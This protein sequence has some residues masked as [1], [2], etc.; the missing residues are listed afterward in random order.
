[1]ICVYEWAQTILAT[2]NCYGPL[3]ERLAPVFNTGAC[4][5]TLLM[6]TLTATTV[7]LFLTWRITVIA[8]SRLFAAII[9]PVRL[10]LV[11]VNLF[12]MTHSIKGCFGC[13]LLW[14]N[15]FRQCDGEITVMKAHSLVRH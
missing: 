15:W 12:L 14:N 7:Q 1:M 3:V 5:A 11:I 8:Q 10:Q 4:I 13:T 9:T 6:P 2:Q